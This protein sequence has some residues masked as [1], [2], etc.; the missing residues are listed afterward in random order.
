MH[1][2]TAEQ[3]CYLNLVEVILQKMKEI[4]SLENPPVST[5]KQINAINTV[6]EFIKAK[7]IKLSCKK[8]PQNTMSVNFNTALLDETMMNL[9]REVIGNDS[10]VE[11][12]IKE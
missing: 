5:N 8:L 2:E 12:V 3:G 1:A 11:D 9:A 6:V 7:H 4:M 10:S